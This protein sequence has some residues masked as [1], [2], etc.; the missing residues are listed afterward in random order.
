MKSGTKASLLADR[1]PERLRSGVEIV[2][3][4]RAAGWET[5]LVGGVVRDLLLGRV[6]ADLD[7]VTAAPTEAVAALFEHTI[8]VGAEFGVVAVVLDGHPYQVASFRREGPYLDGRRPSYVEPADVA[9]D[10]RRRD[11]TINALFYDPL[12]D[13]VLDLVDGRA[14]LDRRLIRTVGDPTARFG[15]DRLRMLR[16]VRFAAELGFAIDPAALAAIVQQAGEIRMVSAERIREE[17]VR[18]LV[19]SGRAEGVRLLAQTGLLAHILPEVAPPTRP[20]G[21]GPG[22][23]LDR[24]ER[25]IAALGH[26]RKPGPV[27][28]MATLLHLVEPADAVE[29][30]CRRLRV[31]TGERRAVAVLVREHTRLE[32]AASL[33]AAEIRGLLRHTR[34]AELLELYRVRAASAGAPPDAYRR[35]AEILAGAGGAVPRPLLK[36]D[37]LIALGHSPGPA[38]SR[39]LEAVEA[40]RGRGEISTADEARAWVRA[41]YP[42]G[43]ARP[44]EEPSPRLDS[45]VNSGG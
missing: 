17:L 30:I 45:R 44:A 18:L 41:H 12:A 7:V 21:G 22:S 8:P 39:M 10:A 38:F 5:F 9:A 6:P 43:A 34:A 28:A 15:E 2:R 25:T 4:L 31:S 3:R 33:R 14:D 29:V 42:A 32:G 13:E 23:D 35:A 11:F 24:F 20:A 27:L 37:D 1:L 16:A 26:L 36:G 19:A 40:A